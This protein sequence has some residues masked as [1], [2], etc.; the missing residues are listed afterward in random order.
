MSKYID[1]L[2]NNN[3]KNIITRHFRLTQGR[4]VTFGIIGMITAFAGLIFFVGGGDVRHIP[5]H[6]KSELRLQ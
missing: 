5:I 4:L 2:S 1:N 6:L 3:N